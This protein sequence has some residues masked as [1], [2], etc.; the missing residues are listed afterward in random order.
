MTQKLPLTNDKT[1]DEEIK[2][3][4]IELTKTNDP[5][6]SDIKSLTN[7]N[8]FVLATT[9]AN[10]TDGQKNSAGD[11]SCTLSPMQQQQQQPADVDTENVDQTDVI[12]I[13]DSE[14]NE[15]TAFTAADYESDE[16]F[17]NLYIFIN[18]AQLSGDDKI[19]RKTL[20][21]YENF[22]IENDLLFKLTAVRNAKKKRLEPIQKRLCIPK[23]FRHELIKFA[24]DNLG[25]FSKQKM[26]L[27]LKERFHWDSMY[28]AISLYVD[29]CPLCLSSKSGKR[30]P[31]QPLNPVIHGA[32]RH[33]QVISIDLKPLNSPTKEGTTNLLII[34]DHF[35]RDTIIKKLKNQ[36]ALSVA[37][38]LLEFIAL[39]GKFD[40]L[41]SD[42]GSQLTGKMFKHLKQMLGYRHHISSSGQP[43]SNGLSEIMIKT[44]L[45]LIR[46]YAKK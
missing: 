31:T 35:S 33:S 45:H 42:M 25:H 2:N 23:A 41:Y 4:D 38:A 37:K 1:S 36:S 34:V 17:K 18:T 3:V 28:Q 39:K 27:T 16:E 19:D 26:Y 21:T 24:H 13:D 44:A 8:S 32:T 11:K 9:V 5:Q 30:R 40:H 10:N 46:T 29:S 7:T 6:V 20:L 15:L 12:S 43:R 22:L 14:L